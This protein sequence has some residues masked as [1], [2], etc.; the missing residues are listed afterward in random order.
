MKSALVLIFGSLACTSA[1]SP[2]SQCRDSVSED[3]IAFFSSAPI[4]FGSNF[5]DSTACAA[6]CE[7]LD[8]CVSWLFSAGGGRCELFATSA[9]A[10]AQNPTF[11]YGGCSNI[12]FA[13][14]SMPPASSTSLIRPSATSALPGTT[15]HAD[16]KRH[17]SAHK[18]KSHRHS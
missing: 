4:T 7:I 12:G 10:T 18:H 5:A 6:K 17:L 3:T 2:S 1:A 8:T 9:V 14:S 13:S 11:V 16:A 15:P